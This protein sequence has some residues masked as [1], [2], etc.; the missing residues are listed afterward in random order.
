M[1]LPGNW[2]KRITLYDD[3][4]KIIYTGQWLG[5]D[6]QAKQ[7]VEECFPELNWLLAEWSDEFPP[8]ITVSS[9]G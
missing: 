3:V 9:E 8:S 7:W 2:G 1:R 6:K 4:Y 5:N